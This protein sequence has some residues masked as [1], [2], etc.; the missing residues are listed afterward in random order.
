MSD[1]VLMCN[2][3]SKFQ[4]LIFISDDILIPVT[5]CAY[6]LCLGLYYLFF[7]PV[8]LSLILTFGFVSAQEY[9]SCSMLFICLSNPEMSPKAAYQYHFQPSYAFSFM[10]LQLSSYCCRVIV[11][12]IFRVM[13]RVEERLCWVVK[14][15]I[16]FENQWLQKWQLVASLDDHGGNKRL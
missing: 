13:N 8:F 4:A 16:I 5:L 15:L 1:I 10:Y 11:V 2:S 14:N 9:I 6:L 3:R 7:K 12:D